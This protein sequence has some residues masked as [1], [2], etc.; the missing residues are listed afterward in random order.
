MKRSSQWFP[1]SSAPAYSRRRRTPL[2]RSLA[3]TRGTW[4]RRIWRNTRS[5]S[6]SEMA[7]S[8]HKINGGL[9]ERDHCG[10]SLQSQARHSRHRVRDNVGELVPT[11]FCPQSREKGL[12][13]GA[14]C[15]RQ[16]R[17]GSGKEL[18]RIIELGY[19]SANLG[20]EMCNVPVVCRHQ[21]YARDEG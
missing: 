20:G 17:H 19:C 11:I 10:R 18:L 16:H 4:K 14:C 15:L 5:I 8:K 1:Q 13:R 2:N 3:P 12:R 7:A 21:R 6:A 9:S